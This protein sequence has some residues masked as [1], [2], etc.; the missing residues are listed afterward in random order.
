[1]LSSHPV[2]IH[3][4]R[5][6]APVHDKALHREDSDPVVGDDGPMTPAEHLR[7]L[8][9]EILEGDES[10]DA[11]RRLESV[12]AENFLETQLFEELTET[13]ALYSPGA[14]PPYVGPAELRERLISVLHDLDQLLREQTK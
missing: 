7:Q 2:A 3:G 14:E 13:L 5:M 10:A 12:L 8:I 11:A 9:D 6:K 1:M 4:L